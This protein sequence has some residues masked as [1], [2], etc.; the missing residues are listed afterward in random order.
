MDFET[1]RLPRLPKPSRMIS[2]EKMVEWEVVDVDI[3][4][5]SLTR[6]SIIQPLYGDSHLYVSKNG[7]HY[8]VGPTGH[9]LPMAVP[10]WDQDV[11]L[12]CHI[13]REIQVHHAIVGGRSVPVLSVD[14]P[15][16]ATPSLTIHDVERI[17]EWTEVERDEWRVEEIISFIHKPSLDSLGWQMWK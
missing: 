4:R 6:T 2:P 17:S 9:Y 15:F 16:R 14:L 3:V 5:A 7:D 13:G 10:E 11:V 12:H 1:L 8:A